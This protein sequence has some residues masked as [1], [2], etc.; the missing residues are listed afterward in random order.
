MQNPSGSG[1]GTQHDVCRPDGRSGGVRPEEGDDPGAPVLGQK[2]VVA[3]ADFGKF[4]AKSRRA[5]KATGPN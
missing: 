4:Q 3:C 2:A 1:G 5:A